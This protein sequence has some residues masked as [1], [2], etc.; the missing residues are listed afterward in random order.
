MN[1]STLY[2]GESDAFDERLLGEEE[3]D[4]YGGQDQHG[5]GHG[6]VPVGVV[7][8]LEG[9]QAVTQGPRAGVLGGVDLG[10][11]VV[12]PGVEELEEGD[13]GDSGLGHRQD[14]PEQG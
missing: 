7:G 1:A 6:E 5:R 12:V 3:H 10:A 4:E 14:D 13:G 8:A 2:A 11:E 9:L